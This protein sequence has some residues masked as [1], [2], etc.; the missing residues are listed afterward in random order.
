MVTYVVVQKLCCI[1]VQK[2][3]KV[4]ED[5][6]AHCTLN[7]GVDIGYGLLGQSRAR[8]RVSYVYEDE[9]REK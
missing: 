8:C 5:G 3:Q 9:I 4:P 6:V 7:C 1:F 2:E